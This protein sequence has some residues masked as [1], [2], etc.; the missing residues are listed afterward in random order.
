MKVQ[1]LYLRQE[2]HHNQNN[3]N[4]W[5]HAHETACVGM[6]GTID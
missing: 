4:D 6:P 2:F 3:N 5:R 1:A